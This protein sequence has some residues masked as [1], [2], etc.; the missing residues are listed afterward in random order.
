M[1]KTTMFTEQISM[2]KVL[3]FIS[4]FIILS[5][6][7]LGIRILGPYVGTTVPVWAALIGI[8][9]AGSAVG[10]YCGGLFADRTQNKWIFL[11]ISI[12]ASVFIILIPT[13]RNI[14]SIIAPN[15]SYGLGALAGSFLLFFVPVMCLSALIT[16]IIRIFVKDISTISQV[17][18]DLYALATT[19]SV[20]G[21]FGTSYILI[22]LF[23]IPDIFYSFGAVLLFFSTTAYFPSLLNGIIY[24]P[25]KNA[26]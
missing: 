4:G 1:I 3:I 7:I 8:T 22:P 20:I 21:I 18:G 14:I 17:H 19:G 25:K 16:Y 9:L 23:T 11:S 13:L 2:M 6:E 26:G 12:I 15:I 10:Y 5:L 24:N